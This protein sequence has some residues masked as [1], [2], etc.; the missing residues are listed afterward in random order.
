M[1]LEA[2][3]AGQGI[4]RRRLIFHYQDTKASAFRACCNA[5]KAIVTWREFLFVRH[6]FALMMPLPQSTGM[7]IASIPTQSR[8][9]LTLFPIR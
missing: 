2:V 1:D 9:L 7:A 6:D 3:Q 5:V 4:R 8:L